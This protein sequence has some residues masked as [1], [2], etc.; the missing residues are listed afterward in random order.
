MYFSINPIEAVPDIFK[1]QTLYHAAVPE[2]VGPVTLS[3]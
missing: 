1:I 3:K 2:T